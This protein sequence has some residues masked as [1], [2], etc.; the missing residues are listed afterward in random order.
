MVLLIDLTAFKVDFGVRPRTC[1]RR[2]E[3]SN[4]YP[5]GHCLLSSVEAMHMASETPRKKDKERKMGMY[6]YIPV[7]LQCL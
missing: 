2:C 3:V 5:D 1:Q 7:W 6:K 4:V